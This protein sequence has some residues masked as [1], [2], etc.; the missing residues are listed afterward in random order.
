MK[1]CCIELFPD[2]KKKKLQ[3]SYN[4]YFFRVPGGYALHDIKTVRPTFHIY[5]VGQS[6]KCRTF[7]SLGF[8]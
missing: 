7:R 8:G 1:M 6:K 3:S 2:H 5:I 4:L